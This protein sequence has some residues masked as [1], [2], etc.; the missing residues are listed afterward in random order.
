MRLKRV[1]ASAIMTTMMVGAFT[2]CGSK[3]VQNNN[4]TSKKSSLVGLVTT[5]G[6]VNDKSFN[7]SADKGINKAKEE[8]DVEYVVIE[9]QRKEDYAENMEA[10]IDEE[11]DIIF[12]TGFQMVDAVKSV[13]ENY[14]NINFAIVDNVVELD[15]VKSIVFKEHEG[16]FLMGVIAGKMTKSNRVG[17]L[18]GRDIELTNRFEVGFAAGVMSVNPEAGKYLINRRTVK[19][20]ESFVDVNKGYEV[21]KSLYD[22]GCDVVYHAAGGAGIG[23]FSAAQEFRNNGKA[24]WCIGVDMDQAETMP[25]YEE[26]IL[27]SMVKRVDVGTYETVKEVANGNFEGG[28]VVQMGLKENA[29]EIAKST[30]NNTPSEVIDLVELYKEA[31]SKGEIKVPS[32][33]DELKHFEAVS[34]EK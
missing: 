30:S 14:E 16:S 11:A 7:Q 6:G 34:I 3:N 2:A 33:F 27:S 18:G 4:E 21:A 15:N 8:F 5:E 32:N 23:M 20:A 31:I 28:K 29:L 12:A 24:V 26:V 10:L 19:Y 1:I 17:F 25:E 9:S 22:E 13:A